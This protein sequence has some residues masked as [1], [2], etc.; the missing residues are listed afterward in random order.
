M[1]SLLV[2]LEGISPLGKMSQYL[3]TTQA[4][5]PTRPAQRGGAGRGL[6]GA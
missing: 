6:I 4:Q 5:P 1:I 3:A 2:E